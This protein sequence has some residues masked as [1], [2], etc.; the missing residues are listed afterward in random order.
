MEVESSNL[1]KAT[2]FLGN[3]MD[4][5]WRV[6]NAMKN[7]NET[8]DTIRGKIRKISHRLG[9]TVSPKRFFNS[10]LKLGKNKEI[11]LLWIDT[12]EARHPENKAYGDKE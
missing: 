2:K 8:S 4:G 3:Q 7:L 9:I 10:R 11:S 6:I 5:N 1:S 12:S